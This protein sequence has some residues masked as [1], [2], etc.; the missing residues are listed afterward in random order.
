[1]NEKRA[2]TCRRKD[3]KIFKLPRRFTRKKCK[4]A[5]GFTMRSSCAP[6]KYCQ[7]GGSTIRKLPKLRKLSKKGKKYHYRLKDPQRKR[8]LAINEGVRSE[9][10]KTGKTMK[11]AAISKKARFNI[12]RIYRKKKKVE[13]CKK[14]TKDM[15][16]MDKKYKLGKTKEICG[17]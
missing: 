1:M 11:K 9:I 17:K 15:R 4:K 13:E 10:K 6:Y 5:R 12:L 3:K 7:R 16:Y 14:I 8:I 2:K